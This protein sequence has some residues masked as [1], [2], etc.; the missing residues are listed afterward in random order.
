MRFIPPPPPVV[1]AGQSFTTA[2]VTDIYGV[3]QLQPIPIA[4]VPR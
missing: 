4:T 2:T 3:Q 1:S